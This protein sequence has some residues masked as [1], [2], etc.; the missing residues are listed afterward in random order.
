MERDNPL[1]EQEKIY[2]QGVSVV[3]WLIKKKE[4]PLLSQ[5]TVGLAN[6]LSDRDESANTSLLHSNPEGEPSSVYVSRE[7]EIELA[8][9]KQEQ[10]SST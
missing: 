10:I 7:D 5:E 3:E 6:P 8:A 1:A 4:V 2:S 9:E